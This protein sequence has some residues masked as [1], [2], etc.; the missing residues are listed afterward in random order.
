MSAPAP[1][2]R[3]SCAAQQVV[4]SVAAPQT[5]SQSGN[6]HALSST[7]GLD[8]ADPRPQ[9]G[10]A[11]SHR[12]GRTLPENQQLLRDLTRPAADRIDEFDGHMTLCPLRGC[13]NIERRT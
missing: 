10:D 9:P 6:S 1:Q 11:P 4:S 2:G 7:S 13:V 5:I 3:T 8:T 12:R